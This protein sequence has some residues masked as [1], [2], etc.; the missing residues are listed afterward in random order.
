MLSYYGV[1]QPEKKPSE[2]TL[3]EWAF[4]FKA[5]ERIRKAENDGK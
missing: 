5:L 1:A 2:M 4:S 3:E